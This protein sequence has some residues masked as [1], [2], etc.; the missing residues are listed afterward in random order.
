MTVG[1]P[2]PLPQGARVS[3][4]FWGTRPELTEVIALARSGALHVEVERFPLSAAHEA[5]TRLRAG[6][7]AGRAVLVPD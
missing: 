4:P 2:G 1:K 7:L 6:T 5:M 3:L